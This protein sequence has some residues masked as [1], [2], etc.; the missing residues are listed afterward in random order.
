[1]KS[2]LHIDNLHY[3]YRSDFWR[4]KRKA[5]SGVSVSVQEGECFGFLGHNGAGKTSTIRCILDM[6]I[7]EQG[8]ILINGVSSRNPDARK[9]LGFVA[10]QPYSYEHLN[11]L[12][13]LQLFAALGKL[14][15]E[16]RKK[17]IYDVLERLELGSRMQDRMRTLS[18]GLMQ[19][20]ALAQAIVHEPRILILD[21]PFSGLDPLGRRL[22]R[23]IFF[24]LKRDGVS[25]FISSHAL[26][27]IEH[28]CDLA[29]ILVQGEIRRE[30]NLK[31][32]ASTAHATRY[33]EVI[34]DVP[35]GISPEC[36]TAPDVEI[37][38]QGALWKCLC[39]SSE[40][41]QTL[42]RKAQDHGIRVEQCLAVQER[43][44]DIFLDTVHS[45]SSTG[46]SSTG[47]SPIGLG[48]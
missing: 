10:E 12:E 26:G 38:Q 31:E 27:D 24:E 46:A 48:D 8:S 14:P 39:P 18:K 30:V 4:K 33:Y 43:L 21:E 45:V 41:A 36:W 17:R 2:V 1:M 37:L 5:L 47:V 13:S 29:C 23:D 25:M 16:R 40:H 28:L 6:C 15:Y 32:K 44:E 19:R 35:D 7:P 34:L 42:L 22:F 9:S 3:S 11:V 20:V